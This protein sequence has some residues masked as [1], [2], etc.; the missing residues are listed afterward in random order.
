MEIPD[1]ELIAEPLSVAE[2]RSWFETNSSPILS[3]SEGLG[4]V[5]MK[6]DNNGKGPKRLL[7]PDWTHAFTSTRGH[8]ETVET[9][10]RA[11]L[12]QGRGN[13][14][15][16]AKMQE[17]GNFGYMVPL[18][19]LVV[20]RDR[21][22]NTT[23]SFIMTMTG[24]VDY[25]ESKNYQLWTNTYF[26]KD[27][28]FSGTVRY[29]NLE[30]NFVNGWQMENGKVTGKFIQLEAMPM[31][32]GETCT[33]HWESVFTL[34][35][36]WTDLQVGEIDDPE[37]YSWEATNCNVDSIEHNYLG[38]TCH[39]TIEDTRT[40]VN[41]WIIPGGGGDPVP[42]VDKFAKTGLATTMDEQIGDSC[43]TAI[44]GYINEEFCGGGRDQHY[45]SDF[46]PRSSR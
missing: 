23:E 44:M 31:T 13:A 29:H 41:P 7:Q 5:S 20:L 43:T 14:A 3:M 37:L 16:K 12:F 38:T 22:K 18:S 8:L 24:D 34:E 19:R 35:Q 17:T 32:P 11:N 40:Y 28:N 4:Q 1:Q 2:A 45:Y 42:P 36:C 6:S 10:L 30:G 15:S 25:I 27:H 21:K 9:H 26:Q 33:V 39:L 46:L